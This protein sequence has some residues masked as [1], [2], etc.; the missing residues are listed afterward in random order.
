MG[1]IEYFIIIFISYVSLIFFPDSYYMLQNNDLK[2]RDL[3]LQIILIIH[4]LYQPCDGRNALKWHLTCVPF[5]EQ[6]QTQLRKRNLHWE[7]SCFSDGTFHSPKPTLRNVYW[8]IS[9]MYEMVSSFR[10]DFKTNYLSNLSN[11][12]FM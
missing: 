11:K 4:E 9:I 1:N 12:Y 7:C 2:Y 6:L 3:Q 10:W 8:E 5:R